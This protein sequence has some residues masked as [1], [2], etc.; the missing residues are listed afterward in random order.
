[1]TVRQHLDLA[2]GLLMT[3]G[4][5]PLGEVD[6]GALM[7][8]LYARALLCEAGASTAITNLAPATTPEQ[9]RTTV[10]AVLAELTQLPLEVFGRP[11]VLDAAD[12]CQQA[13]RYLT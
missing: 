5:A 13:L 9:A 2:A 11:Q 8:C 7:H 6:T 10:R 4:R 1:M 12:A 3:V